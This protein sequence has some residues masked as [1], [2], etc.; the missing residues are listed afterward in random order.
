VAGSKGRLGS[1]PTR[2]EQE[3][4]ECENP[5]FFNLPIT[6]TKEKNTNN[7]A[8]CFKNNPAWLGCD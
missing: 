1:D 2:Y 8:G 6:I 5:H 3:R 4:V 7:G